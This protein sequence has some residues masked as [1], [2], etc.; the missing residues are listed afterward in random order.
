MT[1]TQTTDTKACGHYPIK[2]D[3]T[4]PIKAVTSTA[5]RTHHTKPCGATTYAAELSSLLHKT[6]WTMQSPQIVHQLQA[7]HTIQ[8]A[9][10]SVMRAPVA[11]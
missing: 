11:G 5:A 10:P 2:T 7:R 9:H 1:V 8:A 3:G 6:V 4:N